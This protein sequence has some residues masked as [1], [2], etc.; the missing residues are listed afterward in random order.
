MRRRLLQGRRTMAARSRVANRQWITPSLRYRGAARLLNRVL[1]SDQLD[2]APLI[3]S[4]F[5]AFT[6]TAGDRRLG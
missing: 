2:L 1:L 4:R 5:I 3:F 6:Y